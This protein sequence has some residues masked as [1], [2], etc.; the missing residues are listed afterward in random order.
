MRT[1]VGMTP[2]PDE[3]YGL[4]PVFVFLAPH[5]RSNYSWEVPGDEPEKLSWFEVDLTGITLVADLWE[6]REVTAA[7]VCSGGLWWGDFSPDSAKAPE[8]FRS[9]LDPDGVITFEKLLDEA[10]STAIELSRSAAILA[11]VEA[12]R[13]SLSVRPER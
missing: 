13:L 11:S 2:W 10:V 9:F 12:S 5:Y 1:S 4:R 7:W 6:L 8:A 3:V